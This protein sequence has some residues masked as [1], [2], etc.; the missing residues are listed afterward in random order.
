MG[1]GLLKAESIYRVHKL[2]ASSNDVA[3]GHIGLPENEPQQQCKASDNFKAR[4]Q[5]VC[6]SQLKWDV[7]AQKCIDG[8]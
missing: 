5:N 4:I 2:Y 6:T 3:S 7:F 8:N 1:V